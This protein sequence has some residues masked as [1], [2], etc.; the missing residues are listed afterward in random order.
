ML[1]VLVEFLSKEKKKYTSLS[2][3]KMSRVRFGL[4]IEWM[5]A[6]ERIKTA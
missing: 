2:L 4:G 3:V 1:L 6:V 5:I